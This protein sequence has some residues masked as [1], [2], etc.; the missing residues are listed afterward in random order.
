MDTLIQYNAAQTFEYQ[1]LTEPDGI[2]L[3]VLHPAE[4]LAEIRCSLVHTTLSQCEYEVIDH[5]TA[6]SYVWGDPSILKTI[7]VNQVP[8][9]ITTNL[10]DALLHIRDTSRPIR[11]WADAI[12]IN[13]NDDDERNCQVRM[14]WK[15]YATADHTIIYLGA[16]GKDGESKD[17]LEDTPISELAKEM[18]QRPW[19]TRVW[20]FQELVFSKEPWIQYGRRR[21]KWGYIYDILKKA[22]GPNRLDIQ[23]PDSPLTRSIGLKDKVPAHITEHLNLCVER[24]TDMEKTRQ[25]HHEYHAPGPEMIMLVSGRRGLGATDARDMIFSLTGFASD[26]NAEMLQVDYT[27]PWEKV[28]TEFAIHQVRKDDSCRLLFHVN[29]SRNIEDQAGI[30]SWVPD[31]RMRNIA[32]AQPFP[33]VGRY[34]TV[35]APSLDLRENLKR[36]NF[37]LCLDEPPILLVLGY[38]PETVVRFSVPL[39]FENIPPDDFAILSADF[40][41]IKDQ[42]VDDNPHWRGLSIPDGIECAHMYKNM[43]NFWRGVIRDDEILPKLDEKYIGT[44]RREFS[45]TL[46]GKSI[47]VLPVF[48]K[49]DYTDVPGTREVFNSSSHIPIRD[50]IADCLVAAFD[51]SFDWKFLE[52]RRLARLSSGVLV[53]TPASA[54]LGDIVICTQNLI[55]LRFREPFL[56]RPCSQLQYSS[57]DGDIKSKVNEKMN[58]LRN[59]YASTPKLDI[60]TTPVEHCTFVGPAFMHGMEFCEATTRLAIWEREVRDKE[61]DGGLILPKMIYAIH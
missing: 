29:E 22:T 47:N 1:P 56:L 10:H 57:S 18:V 38:R 41:K 26:G 61:W 55:G 20:V 32:S 60:A 53:L 4:N 50:W 51:P 5:Y 23:N 13:Q 28:Y 19:F 27:K 39:S 15:I 52:G 14:M 33:I 16:H 58:R 21:W 48:S 42:C 17:A 11:M 59:N 40:A 35:K 44:S 54:Q 36:Y 7:R 46:D 45:T 8:V 25:R 37:Q 6:L 31:W 3:L 24:V 49:F 34:D 2:R 12:C 43:Y 30:P 9:K